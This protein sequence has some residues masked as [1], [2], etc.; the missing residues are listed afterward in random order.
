MPAALVWMDACRACSD[1][2]GV[3][4]QVGPRDVDNG[5]VIVKGRCDEDKTEIPFDAATIGAAITGKLD[6]IQAGMLAAAEARLAAMTHSCESYDELKQAMLSLS[7]GNQAQGFWLVP[8]KC[9]AKNEEAIKQ[10]T[11]ATIRCYPFEHNQSPPVGKKCFYSG[12]PATHMA[13]FARAF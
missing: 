1:R 4:V 10:E 12:E 7:E 9:D 8:W 13:L 6:S 11:K 5:V 2:A 3:A